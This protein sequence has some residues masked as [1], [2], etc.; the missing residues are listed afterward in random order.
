MLAL[1][2]SQS[3]GQRPDALPPLRFTSTFQLISP[4][5]NPS[6]VACLST[7]IFRCIFH[8]NTVCTWLR[9][10]LCHSSRNPKPETQQGT[11]MEYGLRKY[12]AWQRFLSFLSFLLYL[13]LAWPISGAYLGSVSDVPLKSAGIEMFKSL[14]FWNQQ[15]W[16]HVKP[17]GGWLVYLAW[18]LALFVG[19]R[20]LWLVLQY[21][22]KWVLSRTFPETDAQ[23][24]HRAGS[25]TATMTDLIVQRKVPDPLLRW[26][27]G[28]R[29]NLLRFVFH[30]HQRA[31]FTF[32]NPHGALM[33]D[34]LLDRQHRL[35][36]IDWQIMNGSWAPFRWILRLL[37]LLGLF[38]TFWLIYQQ[39]Q[40][41]LVGHKDIQ[42]L[43]T[44][45]LPSVLPFVQIMVLILVFGLGYGLVSRL[46]NL[47]LANLDALLYD[48]LLSTMP[49]RS[50]DTI[51]ILE[52][53]QKHFRE[54]NQMI[55]RLERSVSVRK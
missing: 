15:Q 26:S 43:A 23:S 21:F 11:E 28:L 6:Q 12:E 54:V 22:G 50:S 19:G 53:L 45:L 30:A 17:L 40:P 1:P 33:A 32:G 51:L 4:R 24:R 46:E 13:S 25:G 27:Q 37:P 3:F 39:I 20:L 29:K 36:E 48:R 42:E 2:L 14:G 55:E 35:A 44:T 16:V 31:L 38:Q 18:V 34:E 41:V 52:A 49:I 8:E 5:F 7:E 47:Y 10:Y 9:S